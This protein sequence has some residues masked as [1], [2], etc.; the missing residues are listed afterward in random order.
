MNRVL[1]RT[2]ML[3]INDTKYSIDDDLKL[4][5]RLVCYTCISSLNVI[6]IVKFDEVSCCITHVLLY[7]A[8]SVYM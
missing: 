5:S 4:V 8:A 1:K 3:R 2:A 6:L 7:L